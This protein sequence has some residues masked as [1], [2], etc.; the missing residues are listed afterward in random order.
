RTPQAIGA[1]VRDMVA[2]VPRLAPL[3][4]LLAN[5]A[6]Q[7]LPELGDDVQGARL[8]AELR[9]YAG[10]LGSQFTAALTRRGRFSSGERLAIERT[11]GR[12]D[13]LRFLLELRVQQPR[14]TAEVLRAWSQ[15][16]EHYFVAASHLVQRVITAGE[17]DG[18]FGLD[19]AQFADQYV[20]EMNV[21]F[22]LRDAL[23]QH[24]VMKADAE[25]DRARRLIALVGAVSLALLLGVAVGI[26]LVNRRVLRPL[27]GT[28]EALTALAQNE[29]DA[30]LP[31]PQADDEMAAVIG[32]VHTL[33]QQTQRREELEQERDD[34]IERLREQSN[35]DFLTGLPNRRAFHVAAERE[36]ARARRHGYAVT[37]MLFDID[38][39]K[40]FNDRLGHAAGDR[41]LTDVAQ[42]VRRE[43]RAGDLVGRYGGEEFV[44][45]LSH[46]ERERGLQFAERLRAAIAATPIGCAS[47]TVVHCTVSIGVTDSIQHGLALETLLSKADSAMYRAKQGGRNRVE[48]APVNSPAQASDEAT[49]N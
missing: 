6:Q 25:R 23:L 22:G 38:N 27:A 28:A 17:S 11:R 49:S 42:V 37:A 43:M 44:L 32:A 40:S 21:M 20:P 47:E 39:F 26:A 14:H 48:F 18:D 12:V 31:R 10:L 7:S 45:L 34:L 4:S 15:V 13:E 9:E 24:A 3:V 16:Q 36:L 8:T 30:P 46:C 29:L 2:L 35:S 41:A 19:P 33:R 1:A 5:E